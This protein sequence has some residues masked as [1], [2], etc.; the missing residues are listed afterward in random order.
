M[1]EQ[2]FKDLC[3]LDEV[4]EAAGGYVDF[5]PNSDSEIHYDYRAI[6]AYCKQRGIEPIDMTVLELQQFI[7][8]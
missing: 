7:V 6:I 8:A 3:E 4:A 5:H 1:S 2:D